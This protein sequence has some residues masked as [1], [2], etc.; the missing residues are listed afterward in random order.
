MNYLMIVYLVVNF[1]FL[2]CGGVL[3]AFSFLGKQ[4]QQSALTPANVAFALLL[5]EC[6]LTGRISNAVTS[7]R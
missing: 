4:Q 1:L 7:P 3:V 5:N 6:P 2:A